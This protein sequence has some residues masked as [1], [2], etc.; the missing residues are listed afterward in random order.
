MKRQKKDKLKKKRKAVI[1]I[2]SNS[3]HLLIIDQAKDHRTTLW[4]KDI[5]SR[6][7]EGV[8]STKRLSDTAQK[9]TIRAICKNISICNDF[10][11]DDILL[12]GTSALRGVENTSGFLETVRSK[13]GYSIS[14]LSGQAEAEYSF[15]S[16]VEE[17]QS[18]NIAVVDI[19]GGSTEVS[20]SDEVT[21]VDLGAVRLTETFLHSDPVTDSEFKLMIKNI[22]SLI[23][24][25]PRVDDKNIQW[26]GVGNAFATMTDVKNMCNKN[27]KVRNTDLT[28]HDVYTQMKTYKTTQA[29]K[30]ALIPGIMKGR[31]DIILAG[32]AILY[33]LMVYQGI[34]SIR[35][36]FRGLRY[37]YISC[38]EELTHG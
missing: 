10:N 26:V 17:Y 20:T 16:V 34:K 31:E 28:I 35:T 29:H 14:V 30:R 19:G 32:A 21:S 25:Y 1:D 4:D 27:K 15:L 5:Y 3:V 36:S 2:G 11:V 37:G 7:G 38:M 22:Q 24:K 9:R 13:T 8:N 33:C 23:S 6:L 18:Q 12:I